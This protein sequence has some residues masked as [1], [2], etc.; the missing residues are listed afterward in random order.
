MVGLAMGGAGT[1][2]STA[3]G[4]GG[5]HAD[6]FQVGVY[7]SRNMGAAYVSGVLAYGWQDITTDRTVTVAGADR[8]RANFNAHTFAARAEAGY[9]F[10]KAAAGVT[11]YAAAQLTSVYLPGYAEIAVSGSSQFALSFASDTA[12]NVRTELGVRTDKSFAVRDGTLTLRGRAAW[13]HDSNTDRTISPTFQSLPGASFTVSGAR[14]AADGALVSTGIEMKWWNG[15]ALAAAFE[16]EFSNT[17]ES[18]AGKGTV[19]YAW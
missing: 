13:A 6:L 8:L 18:Y 12:A 16:G 17:T 5:G 2:F 14:P 3:Q 10:V 19:R 9:R 7:G 4:L 1:R 11:P 15:W